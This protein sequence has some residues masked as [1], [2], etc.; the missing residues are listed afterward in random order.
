MPTLSL[1]LQNHGSTARDHYMLERNFLAHSQLALLLML[2]AS[3]IL[4]RAR[5]PGPDHPKD[6]E[7]HPYYGLGIPLASIEVAAAFIVIG[8]GCWEYESGIRDLRVRRAFPLSTDPHVV[9]IV[10]MAVV[11]FTI[12]IVLLVSEGEFGS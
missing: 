8:V 12:C 2:L 10:I 7:T 6:H 11:V 4:L 5:L 1:L 9:I 3:S